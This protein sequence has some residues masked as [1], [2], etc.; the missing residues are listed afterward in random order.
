MRLWNRLRSWLR[1][2]LR[3]TRLEN[4]MDA[5][6]RF[7]IEAFAE[8][9]VRSGVPRQEALRR[10]LVEFGGFERAK[11]ECRDARGVNH[12]EGLL[13]DLR[14]GLRTLRKNAGFTALAIV[15]LGVG[16]GANDAVFSVLRAVV[17]R[18][19][20]YRKPEQLTML[21]VT[22]SRPRGWAVTDG[23]TSYR[24]F[25]EWHRQAHTFEDLAIFYKRGWSVV[26]LTGEEPEKVQ[27]E[28]FLANVFTLL[29]VQ[30][31]LGHAFTE[32]DLQRREHVVILSH[33]LWQSRFGGLLQALGHDI[34]IDGKP[35]RVVGVMPPQFRFPFLAGNWEDRVEGEVQLWAP[36]TTNPSEEPSP[37]DPFNLTSPQGAARFQVIARLNPKITVRAAQAEMDT[38]AARLTLQYPDSDK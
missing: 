7:H 14:Y 34:N 38:I 36:L 21:W 27:R 31:L 10:A 6:L 22:D 25:L 37:S 17:L 33:G 19:L 29:G 35:W 2:I 11:E 24:D 18:P 32:E 20:P 4:E 1:A 9:L 26:T 12:V 28:F 3:R 5:E 16:I 13:Q 30:P 8:D 23:S 15:I